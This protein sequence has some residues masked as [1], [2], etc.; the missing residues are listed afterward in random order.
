MT[1]SNKR[2]VI[3]TPGYNPTEEERLEYDRI[4]SEI[5]LRLSH[6]LDTSFII[7]DDGSAVKITSEH[8][9]VIH[10]A[11]NAGK[12]AA[13]KSGVKMIKEA[14]YVLYTDFDFPYTIES[15]ISVVHAIS[16]EKLSPD[17][18][19][20]QR[21]G[22][23]FSKQPFQRRLISALI[24]GLNKYFLG[25]K[26]Y[27]TQ[28]GLKAMKKGKAS[29]ILGM[30]ATNGFLFEIEFISKAE[31]NGLVIVGVPV[32]LREDVEII[33]VSWKTIRKNAVAMF[34]LLVAKISP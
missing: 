29:E 31:K 11:Q 28:A 20:S 12:G 21:S 10:L 30:V 13:I 34:K 3:L 25:L 24:K 5:K 6:F 2:L 19:I 9:T 27:D 18:V 1:E 16:D 32:E 4:A 8:A 14:D 7:I 23:Y 26:H 33:P 15:L 17:L 22:Q